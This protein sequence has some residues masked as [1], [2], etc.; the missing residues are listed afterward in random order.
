MTRWLKWPWS[1][2]RLT[3]GA[4]FRASWDM[5]KAFADLSPFLQH[6]SKECHTTH[7]TDGWS[8]QTDP[9]WMELFSRSAAPPVK[10]QGTTEQCPIGWS[11]GRRFSNLRQCACSSCGNGDSTSFKWFLCSTW[12]SCSTCVCVCTSVSVSLSLSIVTDTH[13]EHIFFQK[14]QTYT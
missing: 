2:L 10:T 4:W 12:V 11:S 13:L 6:R 5:M 1:T 9:F 3:V 8:T 7:A 14:F